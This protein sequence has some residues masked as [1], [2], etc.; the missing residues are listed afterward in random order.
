MPLTAAKS[1]IVFRAAP[2]ESAIV[3]S[4]SSWA[5]K[6]DFGTSWNSL[7]VG[8][9]AYYRHLPTSPNN[10]TLVG[11]SA[12]VGPRFGIGLCSG[13]P[14]T[15]STAGH[16]VGALT[17]G[18]SWLEQDQGAQSY[19]VAF[20]SMAPAKKVGAT[21]T[22]GS[23]FAGVAPTL[24]AGA[25]HATN[26]A[27][28]LLF[29]DIIKGSPN[30]TFRLFA[31]GNAGTAG[32]RTR[33]QFLTLMEA[34]PPSSTGYVYTATQSLAVSEAVDGVLNSINVFYDRTGPEIEL[35]DVALARLT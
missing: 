1:T 33:A 10:I 18:V 15:N 11:N 8:I 28:T 20:T 24:S 30:Y 27:R 22:L 16:W 31:T 35:C 2:N 14:A 12:G 23:N 7:R 6:L 32:D 9:R 3:L 34:Q 29:V 21:F 25:L 4:N 13:T 26:H 17:T 19:T 5:R